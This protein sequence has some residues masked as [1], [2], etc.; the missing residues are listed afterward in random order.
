MYVFWKA[1]LHHRKRLNTPQVNKCC[2]LR[3]RLSNENFDE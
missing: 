2:K 3:A 1:H